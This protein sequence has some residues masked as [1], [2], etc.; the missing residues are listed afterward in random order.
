[1]KRVAGLMLGCLLA[2]AV[3]PAAEPREF[4]LH[5]GAHD[6]ADCS[7]QF[8]LPPSLRTSPT[9]QLQDAQT[10]ERIPIQR[11]GE[12]EAAF[13]LAERLP[14]GTRRR[15]RL[16]QE[17]GAASE[18]VLV[19]CEVD[20]GLATFRVAARPVLSYWV[21]PA[22][23][24]D[25]LDSHFR[26]SGHI[27]PV[28][29]PAGHV[30]TDQFPPGDVHKHGIYTAWVNTEFQG[31]QI[32][33]WNQSKW[34]GTVEHRQLLGT[35]DG[36]VFA[37]LESELAYLDLTAPKGP[38]DALYEEWTIRVFAVRDGNLFEIESRQRCATDDP[39]ILRQY[40]YGGMAVRG[41]YTWQ[42]QIECDFLTSDGKN[43]IEGNYTRPNWVNIHGLVDG[44]PCGLTTFSHP[45]N[46]RS[47]QMVRLHP[48]L[49]YFVFTPVR[50]GEFRISPGETYDSRF[51]YFAADGP[52]DPNKL[53]TVWNDYADP[54]NLEWP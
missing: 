29:T 39:L 24:P 28:W 34:Q 51:R 40:N 23:P 46:F 5:A 2:A 35:T 45:S 52:P 7:V 49:T 8:E 11:V 20:Q 22:E 44:K 9:L 36:P 1:M 42:K 14:A 53:E 19:R 50:L 16:S 32:D 41:P 17:N 27:H 47:P 31:R 26:R 37:S 43:R 15:F 4:V 6:R 10:N 38:R 25:G 3:A 33:F 18:T 13:I 54:P 30:V 21:E 48:E 12:N